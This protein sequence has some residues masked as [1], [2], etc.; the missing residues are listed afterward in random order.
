[1]PR[2]KSWDGQLSLLTQAQLQNLKDASP[3]RDGEVETASPTCRGVR[4]EPRSE[5][6]ASQER[7]PGLTW[8]KK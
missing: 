4:R 3:I 8:P 6:G 5:D 2:N 7:L 1:M